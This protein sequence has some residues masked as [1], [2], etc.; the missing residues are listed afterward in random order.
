M[1]I[2][3]MAHRE[4]QREGKLNSDNQIALLI[5]R[6]VTIREYLDDLEEKKERT[7]FKKVL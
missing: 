3:E 6:A 4:L 2:F 5:D 7:R 1:D